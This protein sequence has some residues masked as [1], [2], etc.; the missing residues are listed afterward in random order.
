MSYK[1]EFSN[2]NADLQV[3]LDRIDGLG[4]VIVPEITTFSFIIEPDDLGLN[5]GEFTAES[6]MTWDLWI[7]SAY[8]TTV[9]YADG[10]FIHLD[11]TFLGYDGYD[12]AYMDGDSVIYVQPTDE[13]VS[14]RIYFWDGC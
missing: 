3:I 1:T 7:S 14:G 6:G 8:N 5:A 12:L 2:V 4:K 9:A 13:I 11:I 10:D